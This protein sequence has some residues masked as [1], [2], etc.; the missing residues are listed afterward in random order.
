MKRI[1]VLCLAVG[2]SISMCGQRLL[3]LEEAIA[4]ARKQSVD[5]AVALNELKAAYWEYRT[6]RADLLPEVNFSATLPSYNKSYNRYQQSDGSYT[7]VKNNNLGADGELSV[8]QNIWLTGGKL[9]LTTSLSYIKQMNGDKQQQFM[10]I[11]LSL[12][13]TQP[14]FGVND[15]KWQRRIAPVRYREAKAEFLSATEEVTRKTLTYFFELLLA[16]EQLSTARQNLQNSEKLYTIAD[17]KRAIGQISDNDHLQLRL[18]VLK[19]KANVTD[20]ESELKAKMFQL[21]AFLGIDERESLELQLPDDVPEVNIT[22][23]DVLDKALQNNSFSHN[24]NRRRLEADYAVAEAKGNMR[25]IDLY[26]S[27][28]LTG[29]NKDFHSVYRSSGWGNNQVVE[30]GVKIPILDWGKRRGKVKVAES[31]RE[32]LRAQTRQ[33]EMDF[34]QEIFLL[35]EHFNN[36]AEQLRIANEADTIAC[37][38]YNA[39][40]QAFMIGQISTLDLNDSQTS[41]DDARQTRIMEMYNYW[42]YFYQ[43]RSLTL[44]DYERGE[45]LSADFEQ[46]IKG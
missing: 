10:N 12:T 31:E 30:I 15:L 7:F 46:I 35:V 13:F 25:Q 26:A 8:D 27:V 37:K 19:A 38:R 28:G 20:C 43:I 17:A 2:W 22:Y 34:N 11:P 1:V 33:E 23:Q 36:Q 44:W 29:Q 9:S 45:E 16:E 5:A 21:R 6:Y 42:N 41:K 40:V 14:L 39:N 32:T 24:I 18:S 3:S 4:L